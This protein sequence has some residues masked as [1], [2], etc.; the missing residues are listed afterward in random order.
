MDFLSVCWSVS[1]G[2]RRAVTCALLWVSLCCISIKRLRILL[3]G[4]DGPQLSCDEGN[5]SQFPSAKRGYVSM[6]NA[7]STASLCW[8]TAQMNATGRLVCWLYSSWRIVKSNLMFRNHTCVSHT[9]TEENKSHRYFF[10]KNV[11]FF[12][13][14]FCFSNH[15][16]RICYCQKDNLKFSW[17]RKK[18]DIIVYKKLKLQKIKI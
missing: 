15:R 4:T 1:A 6:Q 9:S 14:M 11:I 17:K 13:N 7:F 18:A 3:E 5:A 2:T 10:P 12:R 16:G 8:W